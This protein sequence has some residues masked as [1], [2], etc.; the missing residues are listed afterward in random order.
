MILNVIIYDLT[1]LRHIRTAA[2]PAGRRTG[3]GPYIFT[4]QTVIIF[5]TGLYPPCRNGLHP[6]FFSSAAVS[7]AYAANSPFIWKFTTQI[8]YHTL[9][10]LRKR[11]YE[12]D[13]VSLHT[14]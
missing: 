4:T 8:S 12:F 1:A 13:E 5:I 11:G 10:R 7:E 14:V 3:P 9:S 6:C 2:L